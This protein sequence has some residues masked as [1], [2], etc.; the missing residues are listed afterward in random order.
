MDA[1]QILDEGRTLETQLSR[2][3]ASSPPARAFKARLRS[4]SAALQSKHLYVY[5]AHDLVTLVRCALAAGITPDSRYIDGEPV[6]CAAAQRSSSGCLKLLLEAGAD[7]HLT[8][9]YGWTALHHAATHGS[10]ECIR[11]L[12]KYKAAVEVETSSPAGWTPLMGAVDG[13][14]ALACEE[15]LKAGA[16][17]HHGL[18]RSGMQPLHFAARKDKSSV[19]DLLLRAGADIDAPTLVEDFGRTPLLFAAYKGAVA[20]LRLLVERGANVHA[21]D[22]FGDTPLLEAIYSNQLLAVRELLPTSNLSVTNKVGKRALHC[23]AA[24]GFDEILELLLPHV[25]D[26]DVG[27]VPGVLADGT[28]TPVFK[29]TALQVACFAGHYAVTQRLVRLGASR[30]TVNSQGRTPLQDAATHGS[31]S[32]VAALLGEHGTPRMSFEEVNMAD[33]AGFSALH[34]AAIEGSLRTCGLL[35]RAGAQLDATTDDGETPLECAQLEH[36]DHVPLLELL[37][38]N[39]TGPLPGAACDRCAAM[40]DSALMYC[41]GCQAVSYCCPRCATADWL[42]HAAFCKTMREKHRVKWPSAER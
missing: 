29:E 9:S 4:M 21:V 17:A 30:T 20:A 33:H 22:T 18:P 42:R 2:S 31:L 10:M 26:L 14:H 12:L 34:D 15:L 23:C 6:L 37:S 41:S 16:S 3:P 19:I 39:C 8:D 27:T 32:C 1:R 35:M 40:P 28:P 24:R 5:C 36:P 11:L 7:V 13:G 25:T 38:G